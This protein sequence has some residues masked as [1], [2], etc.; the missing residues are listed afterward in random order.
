M[1]FRRGTKVLRFRC[2]VFALSLFGALTLGAPAFAQNCLHDE[3]VNAGLIKPSKSLTCTAGDVRVAQ[4]TNV[5]DLS[6]NPLST[7]IEGSPFD[8]VADFTIVTQANAANSGGR[9]NVGLYFHTDPSKPDALSG[10]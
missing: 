4:V 7:C 10:T 9:D 1:S 2:T 5:R 6:G 8:F 3:A